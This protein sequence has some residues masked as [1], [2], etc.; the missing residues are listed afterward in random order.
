MHVRK[1]K[2]ADFI[3]VKCPRDQCISIETVKQQTF[4]INELV[5]LFVYSLAGLSL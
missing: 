2:A 5:R 1:A 3:V 4:L